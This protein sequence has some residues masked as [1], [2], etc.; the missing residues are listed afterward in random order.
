MHTSVE[1]YVRVDWYNGQTKADI[2]YLDI[3]WVSPVLLL[4]KAARCLQAGVDEKELSFYDVL[5]KRP[6]M[7]NLR[8]LIF[9]LSFIFFTLSTCLYQFSFIYKVILCPEKI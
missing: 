1:S 2:V 8:N 3:A 6:F 7:K 5:R 4:M 9:N